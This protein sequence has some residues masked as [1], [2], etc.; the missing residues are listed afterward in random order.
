MTQNCSICFE[1]YLEI[2]AGFRA[3]CSVDSGD[4]SL[5]VCT[6][7]NRRGP[8][9]WLALRRL[10]PEIQVSGLFCQEHEAWEIVREFQD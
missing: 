6:I 3:F 2:R 9:I 4:Y 8:Q 7:V 10:L 1:K 5:A